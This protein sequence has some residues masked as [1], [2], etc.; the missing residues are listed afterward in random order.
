MNSLAD[1]TVAGL[2]GILALWLGWKYV[3]SPL[4]DRVIE[5]IDWITRN[6]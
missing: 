5:A 6:E 1:Y 4:A 3:L 2:L